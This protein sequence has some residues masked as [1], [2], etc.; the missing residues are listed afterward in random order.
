MT[1]TV[2]VQITRQGLLVTRIAFDDRGEVKVVRENLR[3][4]IQPKLLTAAQ[5]HELVI[6]ALHVDALLVET[7]GEPLSPPVAPEERAQLAK[8]L[9]SGGALSG[10]AMEERKSGW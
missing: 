5:E 6:Q 3:I 8:K 10:I 4:I 9:D 7:G 1:T 2:P